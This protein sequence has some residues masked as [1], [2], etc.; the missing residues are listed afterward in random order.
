MSKG[1]AGGSVYARFRVRDCN[2]VDGT[3][4]H[5]TVFGLKQ[6]PEFAGSPIASASRLRLRSE[7]RGKLPRSKP[8]ILYRVNRGKRGNPRLR[9][10]FVLIHDYVPVKVTT[11]DSRRSSSPHRALRSAWAPARPERRPF[12]GIN[13]GSLPSRPLGTTKTVEL[14]NERPLER[15]VVCGEDGVGKAIQGVSH[16][17]RRTSSNT[18][19]TPY[20]LVS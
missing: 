7:P 19:N 16:G 5:D 20:P 1:K 2:R 3:L 14:L 18:P 11:C 12:A 13:C 9:T 4:R 15:S 8:L 6:K 17:R 10:R